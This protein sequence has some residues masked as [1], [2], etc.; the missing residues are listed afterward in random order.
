M[1]SHSA[2]SP[3]PTDAP[4]RRLAALGRAID[5]A[6]GPRLRSFPWRQTRDPWVILVA[7]VLLQQTQ[8]QRVADRFDEI[9]EL[10]GTPEAVVALGQAGVVERWSGFGYNSRAVRLFRCAQTVVAVHGG[11]VP[12]RRDDL[13]ALP[14]IGPYTAA[15]IRAFAFEEDVAVYDTNVARVIARAALGAPVAA[16]AGWATAQQMVPNERGW[17]YNQAVLDFGATICTARRPACERC[18]I[19]RRCAYARA[20]FSGDDPARTTA[21]TARRQG[22]FRG[23]RREARGAIVE[24]LRQGPRTRQE[25]QEATGMHAHFDAA[26]DGLIADG[27][28]TSS[29]ERLALSN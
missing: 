14:G 11:V 22:T 10:F 9:L 29:T 15:A 8:A 25:L 21:G 6:M 18:P 5:A 7:E 27:L 4:P 17:H 20:G 13:L 2:V 28:V 19:S 24:V 26:L 23:S 3:T 12:H 1:P 16:G